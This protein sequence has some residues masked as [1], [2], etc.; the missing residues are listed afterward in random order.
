MKYSAVLTGLF[1]LI[2]LA[3]PPVWAQTTSGNVIEFDILKDGDPMGTHI[4]EFD[5]RNNLVTSQINIKLKIKMGFITLYGYE[6]SNTE[7]YRGHQL[8]SINAKTNENGN[9]SEVRAS[10]EGD[11]ILV[12]CPEGDYKAPRN[13][14]AATYWHKDMLFKQ[15]ALN[16]QSGQLEALDV[17]MLETGYI[18][19]AGEKVLADH[20]LIRAP[21]DD[22]HIWYHNRTGEMLDL[23]LETQGV[24]IEYERT[25]PVSI[26]TA[27]IE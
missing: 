1:S 18:D 23:R 14:S 17:V 27:S 7:I 15:K 3:C 16:T 22:I 19:V 2:M 9:K 24:K 13:I 20:F 4:I 21:E 6:H 8:V 5:H 26:M 25:T 12:E 10:L 11:A